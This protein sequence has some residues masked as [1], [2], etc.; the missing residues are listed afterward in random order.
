MVEVFKTNICRKKEA[1]QVC[2]LLSM[3][4]PLYKINMDLQDRDNILRVESSAV[5]AEEIIALLADK[6]FYCEVLE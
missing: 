6:G 2:T 5:C 3:Q 1:E 4:F